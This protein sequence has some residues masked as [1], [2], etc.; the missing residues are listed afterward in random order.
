MPTE[1]LD[2]LVQLQNV[3]LDIRES[4]D[5]LSNI[6]PTPENLTILRALNNGLTSYLVVINSY[7]PL[8][9]TSEQVV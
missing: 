9:T 7:I 2:E 6:A 3:V 8:P 1:F 5:R 4:L